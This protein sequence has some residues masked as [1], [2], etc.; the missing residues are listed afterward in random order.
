[1]GLERLAKTWSPICTADE[2]H[3]RQIAGAKKGAGWFRL[4]EGRAGDQPIECDARF[5]SSMPP[6][7]KAYD[8]AF[9]SSS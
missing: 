2:D 1:M 9:F 6:P 7:F 4:L 8:T 3:L 5:P